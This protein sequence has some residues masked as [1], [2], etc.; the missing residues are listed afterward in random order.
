MNLK[1]EIQRR[2]FLRQLGAACAGLGLVQS[3][4]YGQFAS[5]KIIIEMRPTAIISSVIS[6]GAGTLLSLDPRDPRL[7]NN[8]NIRE[9]QIQ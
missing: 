7:F 1:N 8:D 3:V 4:P 9:T 6:Q 2:T 5:L